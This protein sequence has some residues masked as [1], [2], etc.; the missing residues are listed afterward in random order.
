M[1]VEYQRYRFTVDEYER[2]GEAG[3][4]HEDSPVEL[5]DGEIVLMPPIGSGHADSVDRWTDRFVLRFRDVARIRVQNPIRIAP[6]NEPEPD[7][8]L[9]RLPVGS[10]AERHPSAEEVLLVVEIADSSLGED[11][12]RKLPVYARAGIPEVWLV[13]LRNAVVHVYREPSAEGYRV[14]QSHRRG[15]RLAPLAF[16]DRDLDVADLLG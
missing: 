1:A 6:H 14:V 16:P 2:M 15:D 12:R 7:L 8:A 9:V 5:L 10:Y 3:V 13:D 4:F 11:R